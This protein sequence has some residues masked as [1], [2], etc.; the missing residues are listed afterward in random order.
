MLGA[1]AT[2]KP[3]SA[4]P[5]DPSPEPV[6]EWPADGI[7]RTAWALLAVAAIVVV[8]GSVVRGFIGAELFWDANLIIEALPPAL[9][10]LI[11]AAVI[12]GAF[13]WPSS[14]AWL[15]AGASLL[16]VR[17]ALAVTGDAWIASWSNGGGAPPGEA[18]QMLL[19][20]IAAIRELALV[21]AFC[22]LAVGL[23]RGGRWGGEATGWRRVA[24]LAP[25]VAGAVALAGV[26]MY[27][28]AVLQSTLVRPPIEVAYWV[29]LIGNALGGIALAVAATVAIPDRH[30]LPEVTIAAGA[31]LWLLSTGGINLLM[32]FPDPGAFDLIRVFSSG[33]VIGPLGIAAGFALAR[34]FPARS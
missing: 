25:S 14:R 28:A 1:Q 19:I 30:R 13:R 22:A 5:T 29:L 3:M 33:L 4:L 6:W 12:A 23:W 2:M 15:V 21:A 18:E 20:A 24:L 34:L 10:I 11:A 8:I 17:G 27:V 26:G 32:A 31:S 9:P 16:V 7:P